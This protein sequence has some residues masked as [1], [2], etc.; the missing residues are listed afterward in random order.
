MLNFKNQKTN[1]FSDQQPSKKVL[2]TNKK[3][4]YLAGGCFWGVESYFKKLPCVYET[5]IGYA[6]GKTDNTDYSNFPSVS[7]ICTSSSSVMA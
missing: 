1:Q 4:I 2:S 7:K 6:N 3:V 5:E